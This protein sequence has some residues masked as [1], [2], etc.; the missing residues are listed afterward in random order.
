[1]TESEAKVVSLRPGSLLSPQRAAEEENTL[2][3]F[4]H[5][6][7]GRGKVA[8]LDIDQLITARLFRLIVRNSVKSVIDLRPRPVFARP[9][10]KH[11]EVVSYFHAHQVCYFEYALLIQSGQS[12]YSYL[13]NGDD[14]WLDD[15]L[16]YGLSICIYDSESVMSGWPSELRCRLKKSPS[17]SAELHPRSLAGVV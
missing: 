7:D 17:F 16:K 6:M 4:G 3:F 1:M 5:D 12:Q 15:A 8:F 14:R 9:R 11:K 2:D 10:F 13:F